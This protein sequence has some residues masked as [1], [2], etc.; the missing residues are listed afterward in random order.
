MQL[1][2]KD[3]ITKEINDYLVSNK[4][5]GGWV[6]SMVDTIG[7]NTICK[8]IEKEHGISITQAIRT[9]VWDELLEETGM[10]EC[11]NCNSVVE[12]DKIYST[13]EDNDN[14]D[15]KEYCEKCTITNT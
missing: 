14:P 13:H 1:E 2:I 3:A 6:E 11:P 7:V 10:E 12:I 9:K 5:T 15:N 4:K 8:A